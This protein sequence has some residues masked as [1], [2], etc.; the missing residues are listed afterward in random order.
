MMRLHWAAAACGM[1]ACLLAGW[2]IGRAGAEQAAGPAPASVQA[3]ATAAAPARIPLRSVQWF[4]DGTVAVH[5]DRGSPEGLDTLLQRSA[6]ASATVPVQAVATLQGPAAAAARPAPAVAPDCVV[7]EAASDPA[8]YV[9]ALREGTVDERRQALLR[10]RAH[11]AEL[12]DD[13]LAHLVDNDASERVR[14][15]AFQALADSAANDGARTR[16]LLDAQRWNASATVRAEVARRLQTWD[17]AAA[18]VPLDD[19]QRSQR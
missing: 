7:D 6:S 19:P 13:L 2:F 15:L 5:W 14:L 4:A 1:A 10:A 9:K 18:A 8:R 3:S 17:Q 16:A 12:P 11:G